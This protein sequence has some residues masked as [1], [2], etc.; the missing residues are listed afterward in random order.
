MY[1][2][3]ILGAVIL[4]ILL[5]P[6]FG[7]A[8]VDNRPAI[9]L[10]GVKMQAAAHIDGG[11]VYLPLRA[12]GEALG[13]KIGWSEKDGTVSVFKPGKNI[14]IDL[15]NNKVTAND[16]VYYI[17]G[18]DGGTI[19]GD[20]T[21][22]G[23]GFFSG[24][25]GLKVFWDRQ[26]GK[27]ELESIKENAISIKTVKEASENDK[28]KITLQYP[29]IEGLDDKVVQDGINS[30]FK[31][32]A[33]AARNEGL[34]N[35][36]AMEQD[37][38][39]YAGSPNKC[40]TYFDYRLKY[41]QNGFLSVVFVNYQYAGGAHGLTAQTSHTFNLKT[42]EE[43]R[44]GDLF[45][46]GADYVSFISGIVSGEIKERM[47][48]G[49]L[50]ENPLAPFKTIKED[51]DFYLSNG[52]VVVY[53]QQYEYFPYA[54]GIL[55][56]PVEF[57]VLKDMLKPDFSFLAGGAKLLE[58][59]GTPN[60]LDTGETGRVILK[61]NSTTGYT[62]H[63]TI[64]NGDVVKL[65]SGYNVRDSG[66]IGAGSTFIWDFKALQAGRT[67]ITFKYYR[68]WEGEASATAD[69]T[70]EYL[71]QVEEPK[72]CLVSEKYG[73][74]ME[75][76]AFWKGKVEVNEENGSF[77][78]RH[79]TASKNAPIQNPVIINIIQYGSVAKWE[80]DSKKENEPFPY[81]KLG[82]IDGKVFASVFTFS[83][84][85]DDNSPADQKEYAEIM[86][87]AETVL[88][89]FRPLNNQD[90]AAKPG[91]EQSGK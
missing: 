2:K 85:Y 61:G 43:Y 30:T 5:A 16:H 36:G 9:E 87:S 27:I 23:A 33:G 70:V 41:N 90:N 67:K 83:S 64:E 17:S 80:Q 50:P 57:S 24:N 49:L 11:N 63:Y 34:K 72:L 86:S 46:N 13:Y 3:V 68:E 47:A 71:I 14:V 52:A 91:M 89:S 56:F 45:K 8:A 51:Q 18:D 75:A 12:L 29:Q 66:M 7:F 74:S 31:E 78:V 73:F 10:N 28:I 79:V 44:L 55:E 21:Y 32:L 1:K 35:A 26:G 69:N 65:D 84:P 53:F 54:A 15:Q 77:T 19:V 20:R 37:N 22:M 6:A 62:W 25:L 38:S 76:P 82:V 48:E 40:E 81:E 59:S 60:T 39:G 58:A 88:K 4:L 42:G